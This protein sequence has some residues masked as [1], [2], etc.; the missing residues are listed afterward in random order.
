[1]SW[2]IIAPN[3]MKL[4]SFLL[5]YSYILSSVANAALVKFEDWHHQRI[6]LKDVQ[7]HLRWAGSGPPLVLVHGFPQHS[8]CLYSAT[9]YHLIL[10]V[11]SA[12]DMAHN[13]AYL[14]TV[15]HRHLPGQQGHGRVYN[16]SN[17]RLH[18]G[19]RL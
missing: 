7:L 9:G 19:N 11:V 15:L 10:T 4:Y 8:V 17:Q 18:L 6:H 14:S 12:A 2:F 13:W 1:M 16:P 5:V 3:T